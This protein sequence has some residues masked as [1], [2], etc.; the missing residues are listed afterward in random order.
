MF[1]SAFIGDHDKFNF[2][3]LL[4]TLIAFNFA[5]MEKQF[6]ALVHLVA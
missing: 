1:P 5:G 3:T 6:F 4:K 2:I